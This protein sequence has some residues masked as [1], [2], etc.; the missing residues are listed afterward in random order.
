MSP[1]P[2]CGQA[3]TRNVAPFRFQTPIFAACA[4]AE[5]GDC[6]MMF[7]SPMPSQ[8]VLSC[9]NAS[10]FANAHGGQPR[11]RTAVAFFSAIARLRLAFLQRFLV[12]HPI[13]ISRILEFGPGPGFFA[14]GWLEHAPQSVYVAIETDKSCHE[15]LTRLGVELVD[16]ASAVVADLVVMSHVL[17]HVPDPVGFIRSAT[18]GLIPGGV[19]FIEVPCRDWEHK[20][21]DE[22]HVLFF[23][24]APMRKLLTDLGFVDVEL[25]YYGQPLRELK[26][27]SWLH[28]RWIQIRSKLISLGCVAPFAMLRPGMESL[29][30][31]VERAV[32]APFKAHTESVEPAWWLRAVA[33][34]A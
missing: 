29:S 3:N 8:M 33:K 31:P 9:Y 7:A 27:P 19:V 17:E 25:G 32:V 34:K 22:P 12:R 13:G 14:R 20:S 16:D 4:R 18:Q 1:C 6:G 2:V 15:S 10:Y 24:K 23:D 21:L 11:S 30:D 5:C 26:S 28:A